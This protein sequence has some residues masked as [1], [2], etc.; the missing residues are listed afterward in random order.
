MKLVPN[1]KKLPSFQHRLDQ[2]TYFFQV[3]H[4]PVLLLF[5]KMLL[6]A[7]PEMYTVFNYEGNPNPLQASDTV[8]ASNMDEEHTLELGMS[9]E[10]KT[11][12]KAQQTLDDLVRGCS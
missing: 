10:A 8:G 11:K 6:P 7:E 12:H 5:R 4:L 2:E 9:E 1:I 3:L